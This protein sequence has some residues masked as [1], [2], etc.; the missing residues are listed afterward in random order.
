MLINADVTF[1]NCFSCS[2]SLSWNCM[3]KLTSRRLSRVC[4]LWV[5]VCVFC[6]CDA[7]HAAV[8][9]WELADLINN[10]AD[11]TERAPWSSRPPLSFS[12][13]LIVFCFCLHVFC[14]SFVPV[15]AGLFL[16]PPSRLSS[17][18]FPLL[19][20]AFP[21]VL[22]ALCLSPISFSV[23]LSFALPADFCLW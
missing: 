7:A 15:S 21:A 19:L 9:T 11:W 13:P 8:V 23:C 16:P 20:C 14:F 1:N 2:I 5:C 22:L 18:L 4:V 6:L 17:V 3:L 12:F 10:P